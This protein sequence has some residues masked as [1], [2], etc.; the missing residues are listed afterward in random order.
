MS[1]DARIE[2]LMAEWLTETA[3]EQGSAAVHAQSMVAIRGTR[4]RPAW[5]AVVRGGSMSGATGARWW[6][7][8]VGR[9][10]LY[11]LVVTGLILA[12]VA[13]AIVGS[14]LVPA[15]LP[16]AVRAGRERQDRLQQRWR[17]LGGGT[18]WH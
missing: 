9:T 7:G 17:H 4:P 16:P 11:L 14:R 6:P 10:T 12:L 13:A 8:R 18:G 3:S 2:M 1:A 15:E 5:L